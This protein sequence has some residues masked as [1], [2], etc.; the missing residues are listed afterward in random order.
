MKTIFAVVIITALLIGV[1]VG[2]CAADELHMRVAL[3]HLRDAKEQLEKAAPNKG[4][5]REKAIKH[6]DR[7]IEQVMEGIEFSE[8]RHER[9]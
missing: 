3:Q 7:A 1:T 2:I 6:I 4:G 9:Y 8:H 5:H